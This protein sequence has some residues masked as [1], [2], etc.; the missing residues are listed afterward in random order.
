MDK[1]FGFKLPKE[2]HPEF[3]AIIQDLT[4]QEGRELQPQ[5]IYDSFEKVYLS[6][7]QPF[8]LKGFNTVKRHFDS[9]DKASFADVEINLLV[10][11]IE[12]TLHASGNG[13]SMPSAR[14]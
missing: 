13:R 3:G 2:M 8:A 7:S 5:E 10:D 1:E 4:E 14:R 6:V 12:R 9:V 11:G